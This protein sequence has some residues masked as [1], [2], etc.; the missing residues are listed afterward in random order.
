MPGRLGIE[1][2]AKLIFGYNTDMKKPGPTRRLL[3]NFGKLTDAT[4][5]QSH[6]HSNGAE[7][8]YKFD[9]VRTWLFL[10]KRIAQVYRT[11][12]KIPAAENSLQPFVDENDSDIFESF[13]SI[14][15][16]EVNSANT[17]KDGLSREQFEP[18]VTSD[19]LKPLHRFRPVFLLHG[20]GD[21]ITSSR[22][23]KEF[24][25]LLRRPIPGIRQTTDVTFKLIETGEKGHMSALA[26]LSGYRD[27][28]KD[29]M[30]AWNERS[31]LYNF[32]TKVGE[33]ESNLTPNNNFTN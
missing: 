9:A 25:R 30:A 12:Q 4:S 6:K 3:R 5:N 21:R 11:K 8:A 27:V 18:T 2:L 13:K 15:N 22:A 29:G 23:S 19:S 7:Y 24:V 33:Y 10:R 14:K 20:A 32:L 26:A 28:G 1:G 31:M 16:R 17:T